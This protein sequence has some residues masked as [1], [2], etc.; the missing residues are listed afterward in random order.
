M[1]NHNI[2]KFARPIYVFSLFV[3]FCGVL[4]CSNNDIKLEKVTSTSDVLECNTVYSTS[5]KSIV[6]LSE[7][8]IQT[9]QID[10]LED[11]SQSAAIIHDRGKEI[12]LNLIKVTKS[13]GFVREFYSGHG[14]KLELNYQVKR[15]DIGINDIKYQDP[16]YEGD[17]Q[18][19]HEKL[20][21]KINII[22]MR[23]K[24]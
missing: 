15:M 9:G 16:Y 19:W 11:N 7:I 5:R 6:E 3:L 10:T 12:V 8:L 20:Y 18:I 1:K 21:S 23:N 4:G 24:L 22:G 2:G 17:C 14:Y 13:N